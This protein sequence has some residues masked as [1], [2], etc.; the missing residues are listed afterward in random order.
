VAQYDAAVPLSDDGPAKRGS[1]NNPAVAESTAENGGLRIA[2]RALME[3]LIAQGKS[4]DNKSDGYT[5]S[6][7]F[8]ISF[9]Q[10]S[11]E[12]QTFLTA[13][14]SQEDDP[15]S[16][17]RVRVNSAVW[18]FEEFGKAFQCAEGKPMYPEKSCRV[19]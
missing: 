16:V 14:R 1:I 8:F 7:R 18:N 15:Y 10:N 2:Y 13:H 12:N 3:A 17:G 6:Q 9:A 4:A 19:W 5:E 11:C